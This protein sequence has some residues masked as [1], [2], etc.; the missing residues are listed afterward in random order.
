M[1]AAVLAGPASSLIGGTASGLTHAAA[2]QPN[3]SA[4]PMEG[5]VDTLLRVDPAAPAATI[6][7]D[8][9]GEVVRLF[10]R[11]FRDGGELK[12]PDREYVAKLVAVRM[13]MSQPDAEKRVSEV[14][15]QVK[16]DADA[17]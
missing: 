16:A 4:G 14:V 3:Q 15:T 2:T 5:Y 1:G 11:S 6:Q 13:G 10:A 12:S 7:S 17:A 9:R 8:S